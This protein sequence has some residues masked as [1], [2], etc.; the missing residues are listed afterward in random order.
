MFSTYLF[1]REQTTIEKNSLGVL[2]CK[3][4]ILTICVVS[5]A[6]DVHSSLHLLSVFVEGVNHHN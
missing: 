2:Y 1:T 3:L 5:L 4:Q 6:N